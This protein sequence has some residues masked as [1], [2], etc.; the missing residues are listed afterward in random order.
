M[1]ADI[2]FR[3][4]NSYIIQNGGK[5]IEWYVGISKDARYRLFV[6]HKVNEIYDNWIYRTAF[7]SEIARKVEKH[8]LDVLGTKGGTSGGDDSSNMVYAYKINSHTNQ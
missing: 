7:N 3:S 5:Y 4:I 2:I 8:F 1:N 6:E